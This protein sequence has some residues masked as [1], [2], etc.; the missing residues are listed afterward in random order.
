[1]SIPTW[2]G[3][4]PQSPQKGYS[5]DIGMN[6]IRSPMDAGPA[7]QRRRGLSPNNLEVSYI[8]TTSQ[9]ETLQS[10][11]LSEL[12]GVKRFNYTHPR[13][14]QTVE[15]RVVPQGSGLFKL[16]YLAPEYWSVQMTLEVLP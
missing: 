13:T 6:I 15:V 2:P 16:Q 4:L 12:N 7:K 3:D 14:Q 1:M 8:L 9:L 11:I 10:F 5:E